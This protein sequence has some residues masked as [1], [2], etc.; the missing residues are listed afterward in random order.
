VHRLNFEAKESNLHCQSFLFAH[1]GSNVEE[2]CSSDFS[3]M[4]FNSPS[5]KVAL[6]VSPRCK[7]VLLEDP[8][9]ESF[10][11]HP[12]AHFFEDLPQLSQDKQGDCR[13]ESLAILASPMVLTLDAIPWKSLPSVVSWHIPHR[14][15]EDESLKLLACITQP[16]ES[17]MWPLLA[18]GSNLLDSWNLQDLV[19]D[20]QFRSGYA[21]YRSTGSRPFC[22]AVGSARG[23]AGPSRPAGMCSSPPGVP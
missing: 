19:D 23:L 4:T 8:M 14:K 2:I 11:C 17:L 20:L 16:I 13:G 21:E 7:Q 10:A 1:M 5:S 12:K 22:Q 15:A 18:I 3:G 9:T 6:F